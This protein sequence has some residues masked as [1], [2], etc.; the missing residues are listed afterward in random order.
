MSQAAKEREVS[1]AE[2]GRK[3]IQATEAASAWEAQR[4][5]EEARL[6]KLV[7]EAA[8]AQAAGK[9]QL[10]EARQERQGLENMRK[11]WVDEWVGG[12]VA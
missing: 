3:A 12:I 9:K 10:D 4:A 11:V 1:A 7:A 8:A 6:Q 2:K 5:G